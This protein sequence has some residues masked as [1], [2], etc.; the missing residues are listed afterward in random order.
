MTSESL[1]PRSHPRGSR[2]NSPRDR[3]TV[4]RPPTTTSG[5]THQSEE[6]IHQPIGHSTPP[7]M[8]G[9]KWRCWRLWTSAGRSPACRA[10]D[11]RTCM[12]TIRTAGVLRRGSRRSGHTGNGLRAPGQRSP[13]TETVLPPSTVRARGGPED[14]R[15]HPLAREHRHGHG[16]HLSIP[17]ISVELTTPTTTQPH[18]ASSSRR[19][20]PAGVR[21]RSWLYSE[22]RQRPGG[23]CSPP[24]QSA[25]E[26][27]PR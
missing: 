16:E 13:T 12:I 20:E 5:T 17:F 9:S 24:R 1:T 6:C 2:A 18:G 7:S 19:S 25:T 22:A 14:K 21:G 11:S 8:T 15:T 10:V 26:F 4:D 27:G 23:M 3:R